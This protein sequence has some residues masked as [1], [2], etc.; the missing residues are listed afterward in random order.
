MPFEPYIIPEGDVVSVGGVLW[1]SNGA[2]NGMVFPSVTIT[3]S[4]APATYTLVSDTPQT[5]A[6]RDIVL[7]GLGTGGWFDMWRGTEDDLPAEINLLGLTFTEVRAQY[8]LANGCIYYATGTI[9]EPPCGT[10]DVQVTN[11]ADCGDDAFHLEVNIVS[12]TDFPLGNIIAVVNDVQQ[13]PGTQAVVGNNVLAQY[14]AGDV[15]SFIVV[16]SFDPTC[17]YASEDFYY[18]PGTPDI[19]YTVLAAVDAS[20]QGSAIPGQSYLIVSDTTGAGNLW[21]SNVGNIWDGTTFVVPPDNSY[22]FATSATGVEGFWETDGANPPIQIFPPINFLFNTLTGVWV[23]EEFPAA[24]FIADIDIIIQFQCTLGAPEVAYAGPVDEFTGVA[25]SPGCSIPNVSGEIAYFVPQCPLVSPATI[26]S[27]TPTG[28]V[29]PDFSTVGLNNTVRDARSQTND[30]MLVG[31]NFTAYGATPAFRF[32]RMNRDGTIDTVFNTALGTGF[33]GTVFSIGVEESG[34]SIVAGDFTTF[35]GGA[36]IRIARISS[37]GVQDT[38]F[39]ANI[40]TGPNFSIRKVNIT[41]SGQILCAGE[42]NIWNGVAGNNRIILLNPDGTVDA[43]FKTASGTGFNSTP[44][45]CDLDSDG[46]IVMS[47]AFATSYNGNSLLLGGANSIFRINADGSF[48]TVISVGTMFN[49]DPTDV[50]IQ[51]DGKIVVTGTFTD[52]N[53]DTVNNICRLNTDGT[54]DTLFLANTG[55]GFS[56]GA[57]GSAIMPSG[58]IMV[59]SGTGNFNGLAAN[60]LVLLNTD[61]SRDTAYNTGPGPN[62][63]VIS[64][65]VS[66]FGSI[67]IYGTFTSVDGA[68]R[69]RIARLT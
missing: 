26:E 27:F 45:T 8:T 29:D 44:G 57:N 53:G 60:S 33:N 42:F 23:A 13:L 48:D 2:G 24:D 34:S 41:S 32:T 62:N 16:N 56:V 37:T 43:A 14:P 22:V 18:H 64:P 40:G 66:A 30:Q 4:E 68:P 10:L 58:Q 65:V 52:Y 1:T 31:G 7:Q 39:N 25:F 59:G 61:G 6:G 51:A 35:N 47:N 67:W 46:S 17:N 36:T 15:V 12:A 49:N 5:E 55:T 21:A 20:F 11:I 3:F 69:L 63:T 19:D 28:E 54:I 50:S 9:V 38:A